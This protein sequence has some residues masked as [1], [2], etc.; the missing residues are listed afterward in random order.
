MMQV[1]LDKFCS[2]EEALLDLEKVTL[3]D[4]IQ[5][6]RDGSFD[7]YFD[8][9][10]ILG[11]LQHIAQNFGRYY[12]REFCPRCGSANVMNIPTYEGVKPYFHCKECGKKFKHKTFIGT[13]FEDWVISV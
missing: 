9:S 5:M 10:K 2:S 12:G 7:N 8:R 13:H 3:K 1:T 4:V 6:L 11:Y